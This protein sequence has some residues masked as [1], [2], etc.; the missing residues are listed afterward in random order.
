MADNLAPKGRSV[1]YRS[2]PRAKRVSE[3]APFTQA[4]IKR[5][6]VHSQME[7]NTEQTINKIEKMR[8]DTVAKARAHES[9][10]VRTP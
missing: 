10:K 6:E 8:E 3:L 9:N 2:K 5:M 1:G 7:D 4:A